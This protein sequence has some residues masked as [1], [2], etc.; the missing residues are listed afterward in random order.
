MRL[1]PTAFFEGF[2]ITA[3]ESMACGTPVIGTAVP[4]LRDIIENG[5]NGLLVEYGDHVELR[6]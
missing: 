2:G 1:I 3:V 4:G 6:E 5:K